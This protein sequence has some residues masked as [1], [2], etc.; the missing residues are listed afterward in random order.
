MRGQA[1][2]NPLHTFLHRLQIFKDTSLYLGRLLV[3]QQR[4]NRRLDGFLASDSQG[5]DI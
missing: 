5:A 4:T 2:S 3:N 1:V